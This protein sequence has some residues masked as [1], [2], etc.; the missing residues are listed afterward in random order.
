MTTMKSIVNANLIR[1]LLILTILT[2]FV[3]AC[4]QKQKQKQ[5]QEQKQEQEQKQKQQIE[6]SKYIVYPSSDDYQPSNLDRWLEYDSVTFTD[7]SYAVKQLKYSP[8]NSLIRYIDSNGQL[9]ATIAAPSECYPQKLIYGYDEN[10]RLKYLLNFDVLLDGDFEYFTTEDEYLQFRHA[11]DSVDFQHPDLKRH[12]LTEI[13][14]DRD[15]MAREIIERPS[16]GSIKAPENHKLDVRV[17]PCENFWYS[18]IEGGHFILR[19]EV[20]PLDQTCNYTV[21]IFENFAPGT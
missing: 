4:N 15:G 10:R 16:G 21:G 9:M 20:I 5:K 11:I 13:I 3:V 1:H 18:D 7:G 17:V 19:T 8:Q 12:I 2:T 6:I 14:Y